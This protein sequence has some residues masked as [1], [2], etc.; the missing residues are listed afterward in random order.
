MNELQNP[1]NTGKMQEI[2]D[3]KGK[4]IKGVSGNPLGKPLGTKNKVSIVGTINQMFEDDPEMFLDFVNKY[5]KDPKNRQHI[6][7]MIDG[8]PQGIGINIDNRTVNLNYTPD[9]LWAGVRALYKQS[10]LT[11]EEFLNKIR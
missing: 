3:E 6:V 2:R 4:F 8:K 7:E 9:D 10:G 1:E 11:D 5:L